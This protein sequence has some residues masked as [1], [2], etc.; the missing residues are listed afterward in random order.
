MLL[1]E[2]TIDFDPI[3]LIWGGRRLASWVHGQQ[4][5]LVILGS[6]LCVYFLNMNI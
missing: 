5:Y 2:C 6:S 3:I 4:Q 1:N